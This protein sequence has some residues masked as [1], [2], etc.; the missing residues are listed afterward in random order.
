MCLVVDGLCQNLRADGTVCDCPIVAHP[1]E[2]AEGK[3]Y[4]NRFI[5][6]PS[7]F[8]LSIPLLFNELTPWLLLYTY[9]LTAPA[10][11]IAAPGM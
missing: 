3:N 11:A 1:S 10:P 6:V 5:I 7:H 2:T 9:S 8:Y 4:S